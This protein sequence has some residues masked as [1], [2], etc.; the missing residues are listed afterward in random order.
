MD[1]QSRESDVKARV[2]ADQHL[3]INSDTYD[4]S[5]SEVAYTP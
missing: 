2:L 5:G 4:A 3:R 1:P